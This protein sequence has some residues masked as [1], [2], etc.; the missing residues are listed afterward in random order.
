MGLRFRKIFKVA[1]GVKINLS[2]SGLSLSAGRKGATTNLS[3][4]G[5]RST[6]GIP[7][8]GLSYQTKGSFSGSA[9]FIGI[10][11]I[12]I[13]VALAKGWVQL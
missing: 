5:L 6:V 1:P 4:K 3:T 12:L 9:I 8:S 13:A 11:V 2:K 10:L 7:G